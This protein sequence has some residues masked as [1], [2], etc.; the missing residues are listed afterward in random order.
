MNNK[1]DER[2]I[3]AIK[4]GFLYHEVNHYMWETSS[5]KYKSKAAAINLKNQLLADGQQAIIIRL[6]EPNTI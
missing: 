2:Y 4:A 3:V 6:Q 1:K 5:K